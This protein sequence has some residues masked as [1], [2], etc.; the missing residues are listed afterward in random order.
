MT[1]KS[2]AWSIVW[3]LWFFFATI[4]S[5]NCQVQA[6][7]FGVF[8]QGA[9]ALGQAAAVTAHTNGPS[10]IFYNPAL[11]NDLEGTQLEAG[12]TLFVFNREFHSD[13]DG[14]THEMEDKLKFPSTFYLSHVIND[15][16]AAGIGLFFPFGLATDWKDDWEGRYI[17][18]K[19]EMVT[20]T[21]NPVVSYRIHPRVSLAAGLDIVYLDAS[22]ANKLDFS[23]LSADDGSQKFTGDDWGLGY[24]LGMAIQLTDKARLGISYRSA[25]D[26]TIE[27]NAK[28]SDIPSGYESNFPST[29]GEADLT[30]PQQLTFGLAYQVS[31]P[32]IVEV[33]AR[34]EDWS[35]FDELVIKLDQSVGLPPPGVS[36]QATRREWSD[37][38]SFNVGAQYRVNENLALSAGYLYG[39]NPVPDS[40]F[41][42]SIPDSD[43]HLFT[44]G[45]DIDV[46]NAT[47]S[48][49]YG[50]QKQKDRDKDYGDAMGTYSTEAHL[51]AL[52]IGYRFM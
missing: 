23:V 42:P 12:T 3:G 9:S 36:E 19:A 22:L 41:D 38:W 30:L 7:G 17:S 44:L 29:G 48:L 13:D 37:T 1:K 18:T 50:F 14:D 2:S 34:W 20:Y 21:L 24:N 8:T 10:T 33:G 52:S 26:L 28:F 32:L 15:K 51:F 43:T 16:L 4:L 49:G 39:D 27:G 5:W 47:I 46:G 45:A 6:S 11:L 40:S 31:E 25:V 35:S